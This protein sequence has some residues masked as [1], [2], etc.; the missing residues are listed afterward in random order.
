MADKSRSKKNKE[1]LETLFLDGG[2]ASYL[3]KMQARFFANP[4]SV[5]PSWQQYFSSL[6]ED[7]NNAKLNADGPSWKSTNWP[8]DINGEMTSALTSDWG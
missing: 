5:D 8:K 3:E 7:S 6:G 2:N 1:M 4:Q